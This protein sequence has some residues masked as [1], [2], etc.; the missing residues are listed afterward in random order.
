MTVYRDQGAFYNFVDAIA[1][2]GGGDGPEDIMGGLQAVFSML[3]W[4]DKEVCKASQFYY[5]S[6]CCFYAVQTVGHSACCRLAMSW[7][8]IP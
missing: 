5:L 2:I 8:P 1:A 4:G 7:Y 3:S 6:V